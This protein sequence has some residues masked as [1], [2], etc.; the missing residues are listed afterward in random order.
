MEDKDFHPKLTTEGG[1]ARGGLKVWKVNVE[2]RLP[3]PARSHVESSAEVR[4]EV[5]GV[6]V[7]ALLSAPLRS[8][9]NVS[10]ARK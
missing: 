8:K 10:T 6:V 7:V 5:I 9:R 1:E 2:P 3:P 4:I